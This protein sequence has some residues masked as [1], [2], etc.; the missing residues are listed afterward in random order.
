MK[1]PNHHTRRELTN[2]G[3]E[4]LVTTEDLLEELVA[5]DRGKFFLDTDPFGV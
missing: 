4:G 1:R 3:I 2:G 5:V